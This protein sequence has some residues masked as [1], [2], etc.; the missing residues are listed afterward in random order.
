LFA[1]SLQN[2]FQ[3]EKQNGPFS[4]LPYHYIEIGTLLLTQYNAFELLVPVAQFLIDC[5]IFLFLFSASD[6]IRDHQAVR[7]KLLEIQNLRTSKIR[8]GLQQIEAGTQYVKVIVMPFSRSEAFRWL[9]DFSKL[10]PAQ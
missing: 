6:D 1:E 9:F 10:C 3:E 8:G 7:A 2:T 5:F 4:N